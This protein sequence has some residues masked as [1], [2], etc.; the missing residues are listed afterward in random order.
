MFVLYTDANLSFDRSKLVELLSKV[1]SSVA[2]SSHNGDFIT[3]LE[4]GSFLER[5]VSGGG[6]SGAPEQNRR[7][8]NAHEPCECPDLSDTEAT[9][10]LNKRLGLVH[11]SLGALSGD[12]T[13]LSASMRYTYNT[14]MK[15]LFDIE[16][17]ITKTYDIIHKGVDG[18]ATLQSS[19]AQQVL[20][21]RD[22]AKGL[23]K[24]LNAFWGQSFI[25]YE[26]STRDMQNLDTKIQQFF[27]QL[28]L[29]ISQLQQS[30]DAVNKSNAIRASAIL[31]ASLKEKA[32]EINGLSKH[33]YD[34]MNKLETNLGLNQDGTSKLASSLASAADSLADKI[35][36]FPN[37]VSTLLDKAKQN[38][39]AANAKTTAAFASAAQQLLSQLTTK[40]NQKLKQLIDATTASVNKD[41]SVF[42]SALMAPVAAAAKTGAASAAAAR[43]AFIAYSQRSIFTESQAAIDALVSSNTKTIQAFLNKNKPQLDS[44]SV[45]TAS[46]SSVFASL[47]PAASQK[48]ATSQSLITQ[49]A[50]AARDAVDQLLSAFPLKSHDILAS[51]AAISLGVVD[52]VGTETKIGQDGIFGKMITLSD[53]LS[54]K[55]TA[56]SRDSFKAL[57][58]GNALLDKSLSAVDA[59]S[60][61]LDSTIQARFSAALGKVGALTHYPLSTSAIHSDAAAA[62][63]VVRTGRAKIDAATSRDL[64]QGDVSVQSLLASLLAGSRNGTLSVQELRALLRH[65]LGEHR[66]QIQE[67]G[68]IDGDSR[69]ATAAGASAVASSQDALGAVLA[70][71]AARVGPALSDTATARPLHMADTSARELAEAKS[72]LDANK[73]KPV[74]FSASQLSIRSSGANVLSIG[75]SRASDLD[76]SV[77]HAQRLIRLS[78]SS[79]KAARM[80]QE[81]IGDTNQAGSKFEIQLGQA[82]SNTLLGLRATAG[83]TDDLVARFLSF[84]KSNGLGLES[85]KSSLPV[86]TTQ[87]STVSNSTVLSELAQSFGSARNFWRLGSDLVASNMSTSQ[88]S[89]L[90]QIADIWSSFNTSVSSIPVWVKSVIGDKLTKFGNGEQSI[91]RDALRNTTLK[92]TATNALISTDELQQVAAKMDA[93]MQSSPRGI[94]EVSVSTNNNTE[95]AKSLLNA[96]MQ[97][98]STAQMLAGSAAGGAGALGSKAQGLLQNAI[99]SLNTSL[100]HSDAVAGLQAS[101]HMSAMEKQAALNS[102]IA[103]ETSSV[104]NEYEEQ[105]RVQTGISQNRPDFIY[106]NIVKNKADVNMAMSNLLST[107]VA[108]SGDT[109]AN[110]TAAT[111]ASA[112][113]TKFFVRTVQQAFNIYAGV[114]NTSDKF[115]HVYDTFD[116]AVQSIIGGQVVHKRNQVES[117]LNDTRDEIYMQISDLR[118]RLIDETQRHDMMDAKDLETRGDVSDW[119]HQQIEESD[120][121]RNNANNL[122]VQGYLGQQI[123]RTIGNLIDTIESSFKGSAGL[124]TNHLHQLENVR[125]RFPTK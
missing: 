44:L 97:A 49:R 32:S 38:V 19:V 123:N 17:R 34:I 115:A 68:R 35:E 61:K 39:V 51:G 5:T 3:L 124:D 78:D 91:A 103:K 23:S 21:I 85:V 42:V 98:A 99:Q 8:V 12:I 101:M 59:A 82:T 15:H 74:D 69:G 107:A 4:K 58:A 92:S 110:A 54:Q 94:G 27:R 83:A 81:Q 113:M 72:R 102:K 118:K 114:D 26:I 63:D 108:L 20:A 100:A 112:A 125:A 43:A 53:S 86:R 40:T 31:N 50:A 48:K 36:Q 95:Q 6:G 16:T 104:V 88:Q 47:V 120:S 55:D 2:L 116:V 56:A 29:Y 14:A 41:R 24:C 1:D 93:L 87:L 18:K 22:I 46:I 84:L 57:D 96:A 111:A 106:K 28:C 71:L 121:V 77:A 9:S 10:C 89:G 80:V 52:S 7:R 11:V 75:S 122:N 45:K 70:R 90:K 13:Q 73:L 79:G 25:V 67:G 66:L 64:L 37:T 65:Q 105:L 30:E 119:E 109:L 60:S 62:D 117:T 33:V 76:E